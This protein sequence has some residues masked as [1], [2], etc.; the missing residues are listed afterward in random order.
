MS[1]KAI[2]DFLAKGGKITQVERGVSG[3][4]EGS[5]YN[6]WGAPRKAGR[7][8][9]NATPAPVAEDEHDT[10]PEQE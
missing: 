10:D 3:R 1:D 8:P 7:P 9:A 4:T 5:A 2:A 6:A